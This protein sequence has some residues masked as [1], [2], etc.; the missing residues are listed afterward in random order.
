MQNSIVEQR[1]P[2]G[3][4]IT[5]TGN[6][7]KTNCICPKSECPWMKQLTISLKQSPQF[8][9]HYPRTVETLLNRI[10]KKGKDVF[11][12]IDA[13]DPKIDPK[14]L[15]LTI[16]EHAP[17]TSIIVFFSEPNRS[18]FYQYLLAGM[19]GA[20]SKQH[21]PLEIR[22]WLHPKQPEKTLLSPVFS[23][24]LLELIH[25]KQQFLVS[26]FSL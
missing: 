20:I 17:F 1:N 25:Q 24:M 26:S 4:S 15:I 10:K 14:T 11:V 2:I 8:S 22:K 13:D 23:K 9:V 19:E 3:S 5:K 7:F 18:I 16:K 6:D 12:L 21:K